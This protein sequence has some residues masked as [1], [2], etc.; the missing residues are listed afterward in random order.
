MLRHLRGGRFL[1]LGA[2]SSE[3]VIAALG[4]RA[5][6]AGRLRAVMVSSFLLRVALVFNYSPSPSVH[7]WSQLG[8]VTL[9]DRQLD[10]CRSRRILA[11]RPLA[12]AMCNG[13]L[14]GF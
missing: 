7:L 12:V 13:S 1:K 5:H 4:V 11:I 6:E 2:K 9:R 8:L 10:A 14:W 3:R